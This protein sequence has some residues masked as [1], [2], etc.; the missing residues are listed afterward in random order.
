MSTYSQ[1]TK[2]MGLCTICETTCQ[3]TEFV[4]ASDFVQMSQI[5]DMLSAK[6]LGEGRIITYLNQRLELSPVCR[7]SYIAQC[8]LYI[9]VAK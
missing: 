5:D 1:A 3:Q 8:M 9:F 7:I 2:K 4:F 6:Y